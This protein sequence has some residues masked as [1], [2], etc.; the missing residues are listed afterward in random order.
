MGV[1]LGDAVRRNR[2]VTLMLLHPR[3]RQRAELQRMVCARHPA[4]VVVPGRLDVRAVVAD[5]LEYED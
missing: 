2:L 3:D 4:A 5:H 1:G